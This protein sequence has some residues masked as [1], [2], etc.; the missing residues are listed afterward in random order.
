MLPGKKTR[1]SFV[2]GSNLVLF[3][4]SKK[5]DVAFKFLE[6]MS[7]PKIQVEWMRIT[8][9]LPS[10]QSRP[11]A[12][13]FFA[14]KPMILVFGQQMF[15]TASPSHRSG[16]GTN[17]Q[18]HG[19]RY[20]KNCSGHPS[21]ARTKSIWPFK[22]W[23]PYD[24]EIARGPGSS[25]GQLENLL[26]GGW[27][28]GA[29]F[30]LGGLW[31]RSLFGTCGSSWARGGTPVSMAG[32]PSAGSW[33]GSFSFFQR[34]LSSW[35]LCFSPWRFLFS[36]V[37]RT[38]TFSAST[39]GPGCS[40]SGSKITERS[41]RTRVLAG[42]LEHAFISPGWGSLN[43]HGLPFG[44]GGVESTD[45]KTEIPFPHVVFCPGGDNGGGGGRGLAVAL[46]SGIR[47][48]Q[49]VPSIGVGAEKTVLA[50]GP[51]NVFALFDS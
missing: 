28:A 6:F 44:G 12:I 8:T 26:C 3:K 10:V 23:R 7:D 42:P 20:G 36:S 19:R 31:A 50:F 51:A 48:V 39:N 15:D 46:Q 29:G 4:E 30:F 5:K 1:T 41:S 22:S 18:R 24:C 2:G 45:S 34:C 38:S 9:D 13:P 16:M 27:W 17:R 21:D 49:L 43:D 33:W 25:S 40:S 37:S 14:D 11:G 47:G 32:I 35:F